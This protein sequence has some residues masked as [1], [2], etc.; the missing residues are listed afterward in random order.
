[1]VKYTFCLV[2]NIFLSCGNINQNKL[3]EKPKQFN[4]PIV[5]NDTLC[6]SDKIEFKSS[7]LEL[8]NAC[9]ILYNDIL[10]DSIG[11]LY[12]IGKLSEKYNFDSGRT[13]LS[14][15]QVNDTISIKILRMVKFRGIKII[16][17][18]VYLNNDTICLKEKGVQNGKNIQLDS[19]EF[20]EI[21]Y[22][23]KIKK[24]GKK[25]FFKHIK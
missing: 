14:Y 24:K 15:I 17:S 16:S 9:H 25:F 7:D 21:N 11:R 4:Q 10:S 23:F 13:L 5:E 18:L 12:S 8:I 20:E 19:F 22:E 6:F 2:L 1:M 3:E